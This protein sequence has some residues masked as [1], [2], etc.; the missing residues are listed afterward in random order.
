[1]GTHCFIKIPENISK[2][3]PL[4]TGFPRYHII[5][6]KLKDG[7]LLQHLTLE[8]GFITYVPG[9]TEVSFNSDD[10]ESVSLEKTK[11]DLLK[12]P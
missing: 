8:S 11:W 12:H 1:M 9:F 3:L 2:L 10:I 6:V 5:S 7:R 4:A